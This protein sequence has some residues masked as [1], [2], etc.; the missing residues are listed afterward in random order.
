MTASAK[1]LSIER[2]AR[3]GSRQV[4]PVAASPRHAQTAP[5][6]PTASANQAPS[7]HRPRRASPRGLCAARGGCRRAERPGGRGRTRPRS[8]TRQPRQ[9]PSV[10][11]PKVS[12]GPRGPALRA[13]GR[14]GR[15]ARVDTPL[16]PR[17]S[18]DHRHPVLP[19]SHGSAVSVFPQ[20]RP[21]PACGGRRAV[22][23]CSSW[24]CARL[25]GSTYLAFSSETATCTY[26]A[27]R[28]PRRP[29]G[30]G[31]LVLVAGEERASG[32]TTAADLPP[33]PAI[34]PACSKGKTPCSHPALSALCSTSPGRREATSRLW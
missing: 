24:S 12:P 28:S 2:L 33:R 34:R 22:S 7:T 8:T 17:P 26:C 14:D 23:P 6:K 32:K 18:P 29:W 19:A 4:L 20:K 15:S 10:G 31:R 21:R 27:R 3:S 5:A 25:A 30:D 11:C 13:D 1:T 9:A 16:P